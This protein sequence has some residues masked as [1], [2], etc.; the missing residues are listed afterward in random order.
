MKAVLE[1][2]KECFPK[3]PYSEVTV[4]GLHSDDNILLYVF[5]ENGAI[6]GDVAFERGGHAITL[7]VGKHNRRRGVGTALMEKALAEISGPFLYFEVRVSN[8]TAKQFY[9]RLGGI[10]AGM[11]RDYYRDTGEDAEVWILSMVQSSTKSRDF[12]LDNVR[13]I[14]VPEGRFC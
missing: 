8:G 12:Q 14:E 3:S 1:I 11:I 5:E 2:E 7:A 13:K 9:E 10:K 4:L 6:L